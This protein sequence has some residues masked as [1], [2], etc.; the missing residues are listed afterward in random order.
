MK[1]LDPVLEVLDLRTNGRNV[2]VDEK[3]EQVG[4]DEG[5]S[6]RRGVVFT[7][8]VHRILASS[9]TRRPHP[10]W[11][12]YRRCDTIIQET[13]CCGVIRAVWFR[14]DEWSS[15]DFLSETGHS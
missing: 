5:L 15:K 1:L 13:G 6:V 14:C 11:S 2:V 12:G 8:L 4:I 9:S 10:L 7:V 3:P